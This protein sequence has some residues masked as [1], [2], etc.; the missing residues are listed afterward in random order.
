[1]QFNYNFL[2][3]LI[4]DD[5]VTNT[6]KEEGKR[7]LHGNLICKYR[8]SEYISDIYVNGLWINYENNNNN[9]NI[10]Q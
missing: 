6:Y 10:W 8:L 4:L 7:F 3:V 2:F 9:N 1:M 5:S